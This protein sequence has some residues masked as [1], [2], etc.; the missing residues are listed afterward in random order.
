LSVRKPSPNRPYTTSTSSA[1]RVSG[2]TFAVYAPRGFRVQL[3]WLCTC[4]YTRVN[5]RTHAH[6]ASD[7]SAS[8][9]IW[10]H[11]C[12]FARLSPRSSSPPPCLFPRQL[13]S[14]DTCG[15]KR[16]LLIFAR[17][18]APVHAHHCRFSPLFLPTCPVSEPGSRLSM[19]LVFPTP[20]RSL[21]SH[22]SIL[23]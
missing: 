10:L 19:C 22:G 2:H 7:D 4:E 3:D 1:T 13:P 11:I 23:L 17:L 6:L 9:I 21:S 15:N 16:A 8:R 12:E 14:S 18:I 5:V 20:Y